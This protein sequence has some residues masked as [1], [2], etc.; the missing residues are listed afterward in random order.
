MNIIGK[1]NLWFF[2]SGCLIAVSLL[3][4]LSNFYFRGK[5]LNFGIDFTGGTIIS[6]RFEKLP[7]GDQLR[8]ELAKY[9]LKQ[10]IIQTT[11]SQDVSIRTEPLTNEMRAQIL[12][13]M[14]KNFGKM[15]VLEVDMVGPLIGKE[16]RSQAFWALLIA[17]FLIVIYVT[18]RFEFTYAI[19]ALL[20]LVHDAIITT[21]FVA[22]FWID[23]DTS[24]VAAI[25]TILG[26]S[27]N[28]T[29]IIFDRIRENL[30]R[31]NLSKL[32][33]IELANLSVLQTMARS[34]N[35]VLTTEMMLV[36]LLIFGGAT[37]KSFALVLL[38]GF[39]MG[40]Y[41]S[42]FVAAPLVSLWENRGKK[43]K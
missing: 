16:L 23:V 30:H 5:M 35:T 14:E 28:D 42:I 19:A 34:I 1:R 26:Y 24:F 13:D 9:E 22:L 3:A 18:Y 33:F 43:K 32:S 7:S 27:I 2:I 38:F 36:S 4:L 10:N 39:T 21:G 8:K 17:S 40:A 6:L 29:I 20:A 12:A 37:I 11:G 25:L 31:A 15:E 41:S